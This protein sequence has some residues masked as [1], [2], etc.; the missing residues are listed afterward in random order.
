MSAPSSKRRFEVPDPTAVH[1]PH[2]QQ[3]LIGAVVSKRTGGAGS[4]PPPAPEGKY[5][6]YRPG[7]PKKTRPATSVQIE[8]VQQQEQDG[9]AAAPAPTPAAEP[10][11][12]P[13][14]AATDPAPPSTALMGPVPSPLASS[15]ALIPF[16][17]NDPLARYVKFP[18]CLLNIK[19]DPNDPLNP[20][21][22]DIRLEAGPV[23]QTDHGEGQHLI[24]C[25]VQGGSEAAVLFPPGVV[26]FQKMGPGGNWTPYLKHLFEEDKR[27]GEFKR[28]DG[29]EDKLGMAKRDLSIGCMSTPG[30][31][32]PRNPYMEAGVEKAEVLRQWIINYIVAWNLRYA[33]SKLPVA[34]WEAAEKMATMVKDPVDKVRMLCQ[35]MENT[36]NDTA[37]SAFKQ[38]DGFHVVKINKKDGSKSFSF[39]KRCFYKIK[40]AAGTASTPGASASAP[41]PPKPTVTANSSD[42]FVT[43]MYHQALEQGL[44]PVPLNVYEVVNINKPGKPVVVPEKEVRRKLKLGPTVQVRATM[45]IECARPGL[46]HLTMTEVS[47]LDPRSGISQKTTEFAE[48]A[49]MEEGPGGEDGQGAAGTADV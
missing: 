35:S 49:D 15:S 33:G 30:Q 18:S 7:G 8:E 37:M 13:V 29:C 21:K 10:A 43:D 26:T 38:P 1:E 23:Y 24:F 4:D 36:F 11:P 46:V 48:Y 16:A 44:Q 3:P 34:G 22:N 42:P 41:P 47:I 32:T 45:S 25:W 17:K 9:T 28:F 40:K 12:A 27:P 14:Q 5:A 31:I 2:E 39:K 20:E 19:V 6:V